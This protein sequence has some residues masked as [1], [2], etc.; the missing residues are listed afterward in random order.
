MRSEPESTECKDCPV[1]VSGPCRTRLTRHS[2]AS[3][4]KAHSRDSDEF[5]PP[6]GPTPQPGAARESPQ[7]SGLFRSNRFLAEITLGPSSLNPHSG[8]QSDQRDFFLLRS[9]LCQTP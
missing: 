8:P 4:S 5:E 3:F 6:Q 9:K 1:P 7:R 2:I